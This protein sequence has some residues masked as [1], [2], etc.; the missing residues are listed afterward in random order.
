MKVIGKIIK[1]KDMEYFIMK[2]IVIVENLK[3]YL[4]MEIEKDMEHSIS[5]ME[6]NIIVF[7]IIVKELE[8]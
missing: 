7:G 1:E 6:K 3:V 4:K 5:K 2:K 8:K